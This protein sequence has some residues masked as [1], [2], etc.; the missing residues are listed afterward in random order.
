MRLKLN[1]LVDLPG[2]C[3]LAEVLATMRQAA[4]F[5]QPSV[6]AR[7]QDRDGIPNVILEAMAVGVPVVSTDIS[8]IPEVVLHA[9][10]GLLVPER[11]PIALAKAL[12][13]FLDDAALRERT[14]AAARRFVEANF[15]NMRNA[16]RLLELFE[17]YVHGQV[18][19][20]SHPLV[21]VENT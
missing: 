5:A 10:T 20:A 4:V 3:P 7:N 13:R 9:E 1:D 15:D 16:E 18:N 6:I 21:P 12:A 19:E 8:A 11:D 14:T 2:S 17:A